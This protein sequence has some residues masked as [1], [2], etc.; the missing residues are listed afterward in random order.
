MDYKEHEDI[1]A[2]FKRL[3][4]DKD[5]FP[6]LDLYQFI[7]LYIKEETLRKIDSPFESIEIE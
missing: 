1:I 4:K 6:G 3:Q 5:T 2:K 7:D